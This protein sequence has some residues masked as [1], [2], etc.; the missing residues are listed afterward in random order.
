[1]P[2]NPVATS[3]PQNEPTP[4]KVRSRSTFPLSYPNYSTLRYADIFPYLAMH[5]VEGDSIH[6]NSRHELMSLM[7]DSPILSDIIMHKDTFRVPMR[8]IMPRTFE[9][10]YTNPTQGD[11]VPDQVA[12]LLP[13]AGLYRFYQSMIA[14]ADGTLD[15]QTVTNGG[16]RRFLNAIMIAEKFYSDASLLAVLNKRL[17]PRFKVYTELQSEDSAVGKATSAINFDEWIDRYVGPMIKTLFPEILISVD[18]QSGDDTLKYKL[19]TSTDPVL[20]DSGIAYVSLRHLINVMRCNA[21]FNVTISENVTGVQLRE[22]LAPI[23]QNSFAIN[24]DLSEL[25][26]SDVMAYNLVCTHFYVNSHVDFVYSC[27]IWLS[28]MEDLYAKTQSSTNTA[29]IVLPTFTY[30]GIRVMYDICSQQVLTNVFNKMISTGNSQLL[31]AGDVSTEVASWRFLGNMFSFHQSLRHGDYFNGARPNPL[32]VGAVT[33]PVVSNTVSAI[34]MTKNIMLQRFLNAVNRTGRK[35]EEYVAGIFGTLPPKSPDEPEFITHDSFALGKNDTTNQADNLGQFASRLVARDDNMQ[36]TIDVDEPCIIIG[37]ASFDA[38]R[39][40]SKTIT[41]FAFHKNRF[42]MFNPFY[43]YIGDQGIYQSE[44]NGG[45][46]VSTS[47]NYAYTLRHMEYKQNYGIASGGFVNYLPGYAMIAD[48]D[49]DGRGVPYLN[50]ISP[51]GIRSNSAELDRFFPSLT[52]SSAA[53]YFHFIVKF[54]NQI[55]AERNM[56]YAPTIL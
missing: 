12:P 27:K 23:G 34:D 55:N 3:N 39:L 22:A 49:D 1:M 50:E 48:N 20:S 46:T 2:Q 15:E 8:A 40:Y 11:D 4:K 6:F 56:E 28:V 35:F 24:Y 52:N 21:G 43:Q 30:N 45:E 16:L 41:R 10:F 54:H 42:D 53:G 32:A 9:F 29:Q 37:L 33:A 13:T 19:N 18:R 44:L 38:V 7:G 31:T 14:L 25:N 47:A 36:Y 26:I 17:T 5:G 51:E